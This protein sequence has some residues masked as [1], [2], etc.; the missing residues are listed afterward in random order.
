MEF[1]SRVQQ[2]IREQDKK[3]PFFIYYAPQNPH[4]FFGNN[5][6]VPPEYEEKYAN[7]SNPGRRKVLSMVSVLDESVGNI[8]KTLEEQGILDDT[9]IIFMSDVSFIPIIYL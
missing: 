9:Y 4:S 7:V 2:I 6:L 5:L 3:K 1:T 8:T